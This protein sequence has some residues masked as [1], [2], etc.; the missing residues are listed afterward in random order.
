[1]I[2]FWIGV[3]IISLLGVTFYSFLHHSNVITDRIDDFS[4]VSFL[5]MFFI[6]IVRIIQLLL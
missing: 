4:F 3:L 5:I 2:W 6:S 1:M